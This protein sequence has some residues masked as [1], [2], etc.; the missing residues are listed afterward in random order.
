M[1]CRQYKASTFQIIHIKYILQNCS[2]LV[3]YKFYC[4]ILPL[5]PRKEAISRETQRRNLI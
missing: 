4:Y 3:A 2:L 1:I 5:S